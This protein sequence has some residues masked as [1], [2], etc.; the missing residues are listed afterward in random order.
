MAT[1][2]QIKAAYD[3][4]S[5]ASA[6]LEGQLLGFAAIN[7]THNPQVEIVWD[8]F[9]RFAAGVYDCVAQAS[10]RQHGYDQSTSVAALPCFV[11]GDIN[12]ASKVYAAM[13]K[14]PS[15]D[16]IMGGTECARWMRKEQFDRFALARCL[17][18]M[19]VAEVDEGKSVPVQSLTP[20]KTSRRTARWWSWWW[21]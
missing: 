3:A 5:V 19:N 15:T 21:R 12:A 9:Y 18:A 11:K 20:I 17:G 8:T 16:S 13:K 2:E 4:A 1:D 6:F 10:E 14:K 7:V